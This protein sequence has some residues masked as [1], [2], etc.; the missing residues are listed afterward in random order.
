MII[1]HISKVMPP[2]FIVKIP[3]K[4]QRERLEKIGSLYYPPEH[5]FMK[6]G[7]QCGE[8]IMIGSDAH[9]F[10]P[11]AEVGHILLCHHFI[12]GKEA[13]NRTKFFQIDQDDDWSYYC[14]TAFCYNGDR[15]NTFGVWNGTEIIPSKDYVFLQIDP[16][17]V[18]DLPEFVFNSVGMPKIVTNIAFEEAG[19]GLVAPKFRRRTRKEMME[20]MEE[21]KKQVQ[22]L[23]RWLRFKDTAARVTP[24]ILRL[25]KETE[26][27]S[28]EINSIRYEPHSL[29]AFNDKLR[30]M[31][32]PDLSKGDLVY[33]MSIACYMQVEFM[34]TEYIV[35]ESKYVSLKAPKKALAS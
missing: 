3:K 10:F 32:H 7:M 8:I 31:V 16:E 13:G 23:S 14:I 33:V 20:K 22:K 17:P 12:E 18:S 5:L 21:N 4:A 15:N 28:K 29:Y 27:L 19:A 25:E 6:R 34:G 35:S 2:Y 26:N 24:D 9:Q 11:E 1:G 30:T